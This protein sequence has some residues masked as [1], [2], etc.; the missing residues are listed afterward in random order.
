[1]K[2]NLLSQKIQQKVVKAKSAV[3][4][5]EVVK[6]FEENKE[7]YGTPEKRSV[8]IVLTKTESQAAAAKKEI[9]SGKSFA[10]VAKAHSIDPTSKAN[11]GL[12]QGVVKG[13]EEKALSEAVFSAKAHVLSGPVKTPF[14]YYIFEVEKVEAGSSTA[15]KTVE[16]SIKQ[17][18]VATHQQKALTEFVK[19]FKKKWQAKTECRAG[20]V[21]AD[22]KGYKAPKSGA[23]TVTK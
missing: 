17:Q 12:I 1:V 4:H 6:Y 16:A 23:S 19:S 8:R 22:C 2:L 18:L 10:S 9:E 3:T 15:L 7:R 13:E 5:A 14:G 21:V 11:G 20:Y